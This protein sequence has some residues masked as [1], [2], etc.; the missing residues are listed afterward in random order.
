MQLASCFGF[1]GNNMNESLCAM[2]GFRIH[3]LKPII[4]QLPEGIEPK[5]GILI[6][7]DTSQ[8]PNPNPLAQIHLCEY[9]LRKI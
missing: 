5:S 9:A 3:Q 4:G 7:P 2:E 8:H 1:Y 6:F